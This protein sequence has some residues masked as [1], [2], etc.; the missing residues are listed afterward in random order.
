MCLLL[1]GASKLKCII[2]VKHLAL[3]WPI[4]C[5][6]NHSLNKIP[7]ICLIMSGTMTPVDSAE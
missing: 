4:L 2:H 7:I 6:Q 5:A 1:S 3:C